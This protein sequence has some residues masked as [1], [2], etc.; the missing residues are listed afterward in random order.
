MSLL[1]VGT[2]PFEGIPVVEGTCILKD[3]QIE[4]GSYKFPINR[5]TPALIAFASEVARLVGIDPPQALLAG[6]IGKGDGSARVYS[7]ICDTV[8]DRD[9]KFIVFH[10]LMPDVSWLGRIMIRIQDL[11][12]RPVMIADAGFMYVAKMGGMAPEFDLFTPDVGEMAFLADDS[13]P[14]PFYTRGFLLNESLRIPELIS[15]AYQNENAA[16]YLLVKGKVDYV[17]SRDG[18]A[19]QIFEPSVENMEPIG[20]TGDSLTGI[21][22]ALI[23]AGEDIQTAAITACKINRFM[24]LLSGP[25]PAW[26]IKDFLPFVST[27][28]QKAANSH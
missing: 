20:G 15:M 24:G 4:I 9:H 26:G 1:I 7:R 2:V 22:S 17:A 21:V 12:K 10:Y 11:P 8:S 27:A 3:G 6:D 23:V 18:I 25:T 19:A 16:K 5:G 14:H 13:A 28:I